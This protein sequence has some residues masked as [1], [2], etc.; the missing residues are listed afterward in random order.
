MIYAAIGR[1]EKKAIIL[2]VGPTKEEALAAVM[3]G[4]R[5]NV[6]VVKKITQERLDRLIAFGDNDAKDLI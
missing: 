4:F 6:T 1:V 3:H 5:H 2:G